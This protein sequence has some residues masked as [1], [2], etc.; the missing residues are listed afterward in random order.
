MGAKQ[1]VTDGPSSGLNETINSKAHGAADHCQS[2]P[3][4]AIEDPYALEGHLPKS[5]RGI[6]ESVRSAAHL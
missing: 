5:F 2:L 6:P 4:T 3:T 1:D